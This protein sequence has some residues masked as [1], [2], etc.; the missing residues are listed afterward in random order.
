MFH[1][2]DVIDG[3]LAAVVPHPYPR[4]TVGNVKARK[5]HR[6]DGTSKAFLFV[7]CTSR[8]WPSVQMAFLLFWRS[9]ASGSLQTGVAVVR[10]CAQFGEVARR[11]EYLGARSP[12]DER[13]D[14][15]SIVPHQKVSGFLKECLGTRAEL[16]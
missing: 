6:W 13:F 9:S 11:P 16:T 8:D 7:Y 5:A 1:V 10:T 4:D 3:C 14:A 12:T 2:G 15:Q